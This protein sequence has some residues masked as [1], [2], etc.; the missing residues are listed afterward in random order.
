MTLLAN[1]EDNFICIFPSPGFDLMLTLTPA[2]MS[3]DTLA[4]PV[5][6]LLMGWEEELVDILLR[7][8]LGAVDEGNGN[9]IAGLV[10]TGDGDLSGLCTGPDEWL[11]GS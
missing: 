4:G 6:V 10:T 8:T 3:P 7:P 11:S 5:T 9:V 1:M 2:F